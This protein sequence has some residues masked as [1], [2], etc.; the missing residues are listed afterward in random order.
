MDALLVAATLLLAF[1]NGANDNPKGVATLWGTGA[2][3]YRGALALATVSTALGSLCS[4]LL[5]G[6]LLRV[7]TGK[8]LVPEAALDAGFGLAVTAGATLAVLLATRL[9]APVSTTHALL[10]GLLGAGALA[11]GD[12]LRVDTL[13]GS[14]ALPL[15]LGPVL[16]S[17]LALLLVRGV[18]G[19]EGTA[20]LRAI[21][22]PRLRDAS[23]VASACLVG[24]ARGLNDT[25]KIVGLAAGLAGLP[26]LAGVLAVTAAMAAGGWIAARRVSETLAHRLTPMTPAEGLA[27]NLATSLLVV[28]A[29][30]LGLPVSTTHVAT[31][32]IA[33]L[34]L[35]RGGVARRALA[36]IGAAWLLT[37]PLAALASALVLAW[38]R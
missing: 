35:V 2:L 26:E 30:Q 12:E 23:H 21:R 27:G 15:A 29:S 17:A 32:G 5:A 20:A 4:L 8:G 14:L 33:G 13:A 16:G 7:F 36:R 3:S 24:F 34:G 10:G 37:V 19:A 28:G 22:A 6:A 25:P 31:G 9:G 38:I 18:V 1:A 11:A